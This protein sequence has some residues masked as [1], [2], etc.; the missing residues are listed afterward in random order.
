M[1]MLS[2]RPLA[3]LV[4]IILLIGTLAGPALADR[5]DTLYEKGIITKDD[6]VKAKAEGEK[7][8]DWRKKLS[9]L[10]ILS[11]KFNIGLNVLDVQYLNGRAEASPGKSNDSIFV[12]RAELIAW[13]KV[14]DYIPRWHIL[15]DF[16]SSNQI[17]KEAYIDFVPALRLQPYLDRLRF[18]QYRIPVG[19][20]TETSSGLID[21]ISRSFITQAPATNKAAT[22]F[23]TPG[24]PGTLP[25]DPV[26]FDLT[27][28]VGG[29]SNQV[30]RGA[31]TAAPGT[32]AATGAQDFIQE[33]DVYLS[34][35]SKPFELLD[36]DLGLM[37]GNG[38][39]SVGS[40]TDN[41]GIKDFFG[42][43]RVKLRKDFF[44]SMSTIQGKSTNLDSRL[45]GRGKGSY[46]RYLADF[47]FRPVFL[48]GLW[49]QGEFAVGH[50]APQVGSTITPLAFQNPLGGFNVDP[51]DSFEC[52]TSNISNAL[53][54]GGNPIVQNSVFPKTNINCRGET[55]TAWYVYGKYRFQNGWFKD[56]E[57]LGRYEE[58]DP[59]QN[60]SQD[61]LYRT[62]VGFNY[63]FT[64]LPPRIQAK[65]MVNYEFRRH[66][67]DGP[68]RSI[69]TTFDEFGHNA[70][71][72]QLHV[73]WF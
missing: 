33:R 6:W 39:N 3:A 72:V 43:A 10:P 28:Q 47:Q 14:N 4:V 21:F 35:K 69:I 29:G 31:P 30:Y 7:Q 22:A 44:V 11:D 27:N 1:T 41:N 32:L 61:M 49:L 60:V 45:G 42:R 23:S 26:F 56:L 5:D 64:N 17:L 73:R 50:D 34:L 51:F 40:S 54:N 2:L 55:R 58:Y 15:G 59:S 57:L 20:E 36:L 52:R 38:I 9:S 46:D 48:P 63:Y 8:E 53:F 25:E 13:G 67:G 70:L 71:L 66:A 24:L 19:I 18:G 68:G 62:T 37:N 12:R 65:L 16:S